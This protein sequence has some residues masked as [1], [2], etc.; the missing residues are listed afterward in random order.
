MGFLSI[1]SHRHVG[2]VYRAFSLIEIISA[3]GLITIGLGILFSTFSSVY[4]KIKQDEIVENLIRI[5]HEWRM[6]LNKQNHEQLWLNH[7]QTFYGENPYP[8]SD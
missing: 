6:F 5:A 3:I 4:S 1:Q 7:Q 2:V 8:V